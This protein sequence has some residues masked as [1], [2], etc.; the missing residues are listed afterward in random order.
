LEIIMH[1]RSRFALFVLLLFTLPSS[2]FAQSDSDQV[3]A[4]AS[5][6]LKAVSTGD[7]AQLETIMDAQFLATTPAGDVLTKER[8]VPKEADKPVQ[9]LPP[10][11]MDAPLVRIYGSTA[12]LMSKLKSEGGPAMNATFVFDKS[13]SGWKL[14]A[15]HLSPQ[16]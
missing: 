7:R 9:K 4:A 15:L 16:K 3:T 14:V 5:K 13:S 6:W 11:E 12:V 1:S 2:A 8:L 10:M